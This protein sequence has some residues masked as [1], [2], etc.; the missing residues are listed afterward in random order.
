MSRLLPIITYFVVSAV[1]A[2][3]AYVSANASASARK[4]REVILAKS[5]GKV[6]IGTQKANRLH[7]RIKADT[8]DA[9]LPGSLPAKTAHIDDDVVNDEHNDALNSALELASSFVI[10]SMNSKISSP[11]GNSWFSPPGLSTSP[12]II[13]AIKVSKVRSNLSTGPPSS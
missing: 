2:C 3:A 6:A 9:S 12:A 7:F 11:D 8:D 1:L 10:G 13:G 5:N 4:F